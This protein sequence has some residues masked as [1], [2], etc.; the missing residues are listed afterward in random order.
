MKQCKMSAARPFDEGESHSNCARVSLTDRLEC[1][2]LS[3]L[4]PLVQKWRLI[5]SGG[6]HSLHLKYKITLLVIVRAL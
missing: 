5:L 1:R 6:W 2:F 3:K 4:F